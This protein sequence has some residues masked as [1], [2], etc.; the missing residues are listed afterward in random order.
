M[1]EEKKYKCGIIGSS[2]MVGSCLRKYFEKKSNYEL[3]L[4]DKGQNV[5]SM[6][7]INKAD[8]IYVCV[9]TPYDDELG[10]DTR[11]VDDVISKII[12]KKIIIIKST[13]TPGT[14]EKLQKV[15]PYHKIL[16]NPE[17]LTEMTA[18]Q[19]MN[20]P[21]RQIIGY[22]DKSYTSAKDVLLQLPLAPLER[23][24]PAT[25][26][27]MIKYAG[28]CWFSTK[29][30]YANQLYDLCEEIGIDYKTVLE[31][32]AADKR[33][34]RTHLKIFHKGYKG[35]GGA[36]LP[37]DIKALLKLAEEKGVDLSVLKE[38]NAYNDKILKEQGLDPLNTDLGTKRVEN[39]KS[40]SISKEIRIKK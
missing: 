40:Y 7:E 1:S 3:Y 36:C 26:A 4:Y 16:F 24:V 33:I 5:G 28:N 27:E 11:I 21:D 34:G 8:F 30:S 17:F 37:K 32:M 15:Y 14:T 12:G 18:D 39:E 23:I 19:D 6:E 9:P 13:V 22:T 20:Y 38:V 29:V 25:A 10:C 2:G 31:G 35:F